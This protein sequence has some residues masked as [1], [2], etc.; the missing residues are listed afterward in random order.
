MTPRQRIP[1]PLDIAVGARIR[2]RRTVL[3]VT[4]SALADGLGISFQQVQ[5]YENGSNRVGPARLQGIAKILGTTPATFFGEETIEPGVIGVIEG[6]QHLMGMSDGIA[7]NRA[8]VR[9]RD[10][11]VRIAV[12]E[13]VE[14]I[15][16]SEESG[17]TPL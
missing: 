16:I 4:L 6:I 11:R 3:G 5:K 13:L 9:I 2:A 7:L 14:S 12:V 1:S 17:D 8:F 10:P 15:A